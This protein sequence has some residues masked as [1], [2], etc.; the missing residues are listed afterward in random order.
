[1]RRRARD[2]ARRAVEQETAV[3]REEQLRRRRVR[4]RPRHVAQTVEQRDLSLQQRY[5]QLDAENE[6]EWEGRLQRM[7]THQSECLAIEST[8]EREARLLQ[9][10]CCL[11]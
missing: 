9:R 2:R 8:E 3:E 10:R 6:Q 7:S 5:N 1:M 4:D 11:A